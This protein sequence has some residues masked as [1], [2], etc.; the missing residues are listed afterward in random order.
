MKSK[1]LQNIVLSKYQKGDTGTEM[2]HDLN[3]GISLA[4]I[5]R[6]CQMI[7]QFSSIQL[8]GTR[9][10]P[11]I[12]RTIKKIFEKLRIVC[13]ENRRYQFEDFR[14]NS[15]FQQQVSDEY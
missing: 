9:G 3:S 1:D 15:V 14:G 7:H 5:K 11:Q 6:W 12:V 8:L 13:I 4:S 10:G 2:H